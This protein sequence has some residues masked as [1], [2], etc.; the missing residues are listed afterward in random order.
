MQKNG[1]S[2]GALKKP[3]PK[4]VQLSREEILKN[5][6]DFPK[7]KEQF[8]ASLRKGKNRGVSKQAVYVELDEE[9]ILVAVQQVYHV[10]YQI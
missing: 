10:G 3:R 9:E 5:M 8:I 4:R 2:N 6:A 7:R 1:K